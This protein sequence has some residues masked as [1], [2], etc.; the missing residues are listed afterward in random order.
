MKPKQSNFLLAAARRNELIVED[1]HKRKGWRT[2]TFDYDEAEKIL[3][4]ESDYFK[5]VR[6][7]TLANATEE[8]D[9]NQ[10]EGD[11]D[12]SDGENSSEPLE[13][14]SPQHSELSSPLVSSDEEDDDNDLDPEEE[15]AD[16]LDREHS[17]REEL[18]LWRLLEKPA[19]PRLNT[20]FTT[21]DG[22]DKDAARRP[23][24][25]R[26]APQ[27]M[28][29]WRDRMLY[30]SEWEEYGYDLG[31]IEDALVANR[32]KRRRIDEPLSASVV[33]SDDDEDDEL[34][35]L[36]AEEH[37]RVEPPKYGSAGWDAFLHS[38]LGE[39]QA[40]PGGN[41]L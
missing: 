26:K 31:D 8:D 22:Q 6:D 35:Q 19:P 41:R 23:A 5:H 7:A 39:S 2:R 25:E 14:P 13:V 21:E 17:R 30:R 15:H 24:A 12:P 29:E 20:P 36:G 32:R 16:T 11:K 28:V 10:A 37:T 40:Q 34:P 1:R 9:E 27:D 18:N 4:G 38:F 3:N 33:N